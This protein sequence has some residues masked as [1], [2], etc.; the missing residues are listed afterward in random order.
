V[1]VNVGFLPSEAGPSVRYHKVASRPTHIY[2]SSLH[3]R[4]KRWRSRH[5]RAFAIG[6]VGMPGRVFTVAVVAL[7]VL[8]E[9]L[10][11]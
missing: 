11:G 8:A 1:C 9:R 10:V 2:A 7:G 4:D 6:S 5:R 3:R